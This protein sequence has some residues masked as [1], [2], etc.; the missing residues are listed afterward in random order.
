MKKTPRY[1]MFALLYFSQGSI[2]AYFTA[3]NALYLKSF[4][5]S[6][7]KVGI[8]GAIGLIPFV[9]KIFFGM[10][11]DKI[12]FF[13]LGFRKPYIILGLVIQVGCLLAVPLLDPGQNFAQ[14]ALLA[15]VMMM[16][17][18]L[19]D[20]CTDGLA[21]D[22]TPE[23]EE[24]IIQGFMVGGR[25]AGMVI[26]SGMLGLVVQHISWPA[27]FIL[28]AV[29]TLLPLP[30]VLKN[31]EVERT[32]NAYFEWSAFKSFKQSSVIALGVLGALYSLIING[33]NQLVNPF[34]VDRFSI[35][36]ATAGYIAM[37]MGLGTMAG[38][39]IG[40]SITDQI[41]Q[42]R[43]VQ[44]AVTASIFGVGVLPFISVPWM[45]W[46][47]VFIFGFSFGF[48]ETIYFA[49]SMRKT[50]GRIA[51][52]MF[53]ILMAVANI[54]TGIGLAL[55]GFLSDLAG[56]SITFFILAALNFL[57]LPLIGV[58]F[59]KAHTNQGRQ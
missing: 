43:S 51:A 12:N 34:L 4:G 20:T 27:G 47:L 18:A 33:A 23:E 15:F 32:A 59:K 7:G 29:I 16:G 11:S 38:G 57:A 13:G 9:L 31:K 30:L 42:K 58:I 1:I 10:L 26:T 6:M 53:S 14:Y 54:G 35:D 2:M 21:L 46:L 39:L 45:A 5:L 41:G 28:L 55:T 24:G 37:V 25:A 56:F 50:D 3:L 8:I 52:T 40:G 17:M 48:Y 44:A 19:Y 22:S 36:L 49:I